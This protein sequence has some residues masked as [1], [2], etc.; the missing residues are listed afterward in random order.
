MDLSFDG[1]NQWNI[2]VVNFGK[3]IDYTRKYS[4]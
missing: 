2:R 4:N 3:G 1:N